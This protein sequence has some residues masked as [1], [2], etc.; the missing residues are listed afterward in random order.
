MLRKILITSFFCLI[1]VCHTTF[2]QTQPAKAE[3]NKPNAQTEIG[4]K[5]SDLNPRPQMV[6]HRLSL[7]RNQRAGVRRSDAE[8]NHKRDD[9]R[10]SDCRAGNRAAKKF[11]VRFFAEQPID[12][13]ADERCE[14][15]QT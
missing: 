3:P 11:A 8:R 4:T 5:I 7:R 12:N 13:R 2:G 14:N 6:K 10:N 1:V 15:N 9:R